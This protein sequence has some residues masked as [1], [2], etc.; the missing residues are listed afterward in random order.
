[1]A[2]VFA[3]IL[4]ATIGLLLAYPDAVAISKSTISTAPI[5]YIFLPFEVAPAIILVLLVYYCAILSIRQIKAKTL[6]KGVLFGIASI[7]LLTYSAFYYTKNYVWPRQDYQTVAAIIGPIPKMNSKELDR[8]A[9]NYLSFSN[10]TGQRI[11]ILNALLERDN[12][13][14]ELLDKIAKIKDAAIY[15]KLYS[16][17]GLLGKNTKGL[18]VARLIPK[19][20]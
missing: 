13:S 20:Q 15:D 3:F 16:R 9:D 17:Y 1:M 14:P 8:L 7:L 6:L 5:D 4:A 10:D 19:A 2:H 12:L 11:F 18:S